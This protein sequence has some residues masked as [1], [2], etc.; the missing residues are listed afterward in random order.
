MMAQSGLTPTPMSTS[1]TSQFTW[2]EVLSECIQAAVTQYEQVEVQILSVSRTAAVCFPPL[3]EITHLTPSRRNSLIQSVVVRS[4]LM[5]QQV[6]SEYDDTTIWSI[7]FSRQ[8]LPLTITVTHFLPPTLPS[9]AFFHFKTNTGQIG[10]FCSFFSIL[11][12]YF[13]FEYKGRFFHLEEC[14]SPVGKYLFALSLAKLFHMIAL[15]PSAQ[16]LI[17]STLHLPIPFYPLF[18][19]AAV[20]LKQAKCHKINRTEM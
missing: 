9:N 13:S 6:D 17:P 2:M 18:T 11:L 14:F 19:P 12:C 3:E 5:E 8:L 1:S 20:L 10:C 15:P 7:I 16:L 4:Q